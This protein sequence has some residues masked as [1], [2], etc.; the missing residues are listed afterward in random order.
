[1]KMESGKYLRKT[2]QQY[3]RIKI[4]ENKVEEKYLLTDYFDMME[5]VIDEIERYL[6]KQVEYTMQVKAY[7]QAELNKE[8]IKDWINAKWIKE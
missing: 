5:E 7:Q 3:F 1:M 8:N 4:K 2:I 6:F